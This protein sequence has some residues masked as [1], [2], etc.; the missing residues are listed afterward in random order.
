MRGLRDNVKRRSIFEYYRK[1]CQILC[2]QETHS[3]IEDAE[4]W[5]NEWGGSIYF[6]HG[7]SNSRGVAI[8]IKHGTNLKVDKISEINGHGN[9]RIICITC[10]VNDSKLCIVNIYA[11]NRD[12]PLFFERVFDTVFLESERMIV[13]GDYNTV[14]NPALDRNQ[15]IEKHNSQSA[16][17]IKAKMNELSLCEVW[18]DRNPE[19]R[20]YSWYRSMQK[21]CLQRSRLDYAV[22][23][24]GISPDDTRILLHNWY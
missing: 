12:T 8:C 22:I 14:L 24:N 19:V 23:S 20:R 5:T 11:P 4:Q 15:C 2:L 17:M 16:T 13:V 9:G 21:N 18:R 1:R 7:E 6:S 3:T 10:F